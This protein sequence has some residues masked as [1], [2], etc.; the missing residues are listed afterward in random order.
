MKTLLNKMTQ[1]KFFMH[2]IVYHF[3]EAHNATLTVMGNGEH[4]FYTD[5]QMLF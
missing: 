1:W 4:W 5:E 3:I 2:S